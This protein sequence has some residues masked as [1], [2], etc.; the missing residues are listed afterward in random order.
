MFPKQRI[1]YFY[2]R[3]DEFVLLIGQWGA[4]IHKAS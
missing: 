4:S 1:D 3:R 2:I